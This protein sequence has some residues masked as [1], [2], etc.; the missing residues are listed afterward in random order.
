MKFFWGESWS[1]TKN[2]VEFPLLNG[3][4]V[5]SWMLEGLY[6]SIFFPSGA[7]KLNQANR[8]TEKEEACFGQDTGY[9]WNIMVFP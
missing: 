1:F 6:G 8:G 5:I 4:N 9:E 3:D 7:A 2:R